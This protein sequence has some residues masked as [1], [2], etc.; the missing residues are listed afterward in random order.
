MFNKFKLQTGFWL[1]FSCFIILIIMT[2]YF[3]INH[4][5]LKEYKHV[6]ITNANQ[7]NVKVSQ[8]I[9]FYFSDLNQLSKNSVSNQ[10]LVNDIKTLDQLP[11]LTVYDNL[12]FDRSFESYSSY[13]VNYSSLNTSKVY[14][15]GRQ[16][17]FKFAYG[18]LPLESNFEAIVEKT[19]DVSKLFSHSNVL[20]YFE[21]E[22]T[23]ND[24]SASKASLSI[25]RPFS[26][27]SGSVLGYIEV[28]QDYSTLKDITHLETGGD[29]Y[30][31]NPEGQIIFPSTKLDPDTLQS[32]QQAALTS[33]EGWD[34]GSDF[35]TAFTS[36]ETGLTTVIRHPNHSIFEPL[37]TLQKTT[38]F[39]I[40]STICL[41]VVIV[42]IITLRMTAPIRKLRSTV[43]KLDYDNFKL[44]SNFHSPNNEVNLLNDAFQTMIHRLKHSMDNELMY[45]E[46]ELKARFSALQGQ[47]SPHFIHN[48]LYLISISA[49]E[50]KNQDVI[51]LSKNL[52]NMLRYMAD[53][54]FNKVTLEEEIKYA[55]NYLYLMQS[56]YED[57]ISYDI[58]VTDEAKRI[59]LPRLTLQPFIEN[60]IQHAF[61]QCTPPWRIHIAC[62][63]SN[64]AWRLTI[65][66]NGSGITADDLSR[67]RKNIAAILEDP[68][69]HHTAS[70]GIGG[71]GILNTVTRL[72]LTYPDSLQF[73][74]DN[75]PDSG[76]TVQIQADVQ[77]ND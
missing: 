25:I 47:I 74:I 27:I 18:S 51:E 37:Y 48:V 10:N 73:D 31:V 65:S 8:Q 3:F 64:G 1:V 39:T 19:D 13:L 41:A 24:A 29:V 36:D 59:V 23:S 55:Q 53:S 32:I 15:Y 4:Y 66:D 60:S 17:R 56:K 46:E 34:H 69:A 22:N 26:D 75:H 49:E 76:L 20:F 12:Y 54:P 57:F 9:D 16:N 7:L 30:V 40:L 44:F 58:A 72:K 63:V 6:M 28:Q 35:F 62:M 43:L 68:A 50:N 71:M 5:V 70:T 33:G 61:N 2:V 67:M 11:S 38:L 52:S 21:N 14:I 42:Y 77:P 45:K